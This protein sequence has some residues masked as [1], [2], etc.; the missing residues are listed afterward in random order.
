MLG[1]QKSAFFSANH[2]SYLLYGSASTRTVRKIES[3]LFVFPIGGQSVLRTSCRISV[4]ASTVTYL[5]AMPEYID[6]LF[7]E[8]RLPSVEQTK[9]DNRIRYL[10]IGFDASRM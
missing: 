9:D 3:T 10:A 6:L 4:S 5:C 1:N 8:H 7:W 2:C